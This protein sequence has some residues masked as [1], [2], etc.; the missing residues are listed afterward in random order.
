MKIFVAV[1]LA[2][3]L[4]ACAATTGSGL[5][6]ADTASAPRLELDEAASRYKVAPTFPKRVSKAELR[7]ADRLS[8]RIKAE[9]DGTISAQ[10]KLCVG[11]S[12]SV[13]EIAML[14]TSGMSEYDEAVIAEVG[15][16]QFERFAAPAG[17]RVCENLTVAYQ[18]R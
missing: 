13:D 15:D 3:P 1:A 5:P 11:A 4:A 16:W 8:H 2:A 6:G 18:A 12:G 10:V 14:A 7:A 9:H 17:T